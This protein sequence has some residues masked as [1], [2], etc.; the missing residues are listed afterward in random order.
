MS[1]GGKGGSQTTKV[2]V[3]DWMDK[4]A[5]RALARGEDTAQ[6]GYTPYYGPDVAA[7]NPMQT[8]AMQNT[9]D[10]AKQFGMQSSMPQMP[11]AQD[12][13]GMQ[14]YSSGGLFDQAVAELQARRPNQA[15]QMQGLFVDPVETRLGEPPIRPG[16]TPTPTQ[17]RPDP[18]PWRAKTD[19]YR[20]EP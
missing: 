17:P 11:Q 5:Q 9:S 1:G 6:I 14:A 8:S 13:G 16:M 7:L 20:W 10:W 4:G 2:E 19:P 15:A 18:Q 3:P 12:F